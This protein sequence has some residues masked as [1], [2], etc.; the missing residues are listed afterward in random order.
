MTDKLLGL[1]AE[2]GRARR[3][4]EFLRG[5]ERKLC[6][7]VRRALPFVARK[8]MP[9]KL[10]EVSASPITELR[11]KSAQ[12]AA[13]LELV[14]EPGGSRA[15][16][17]FDGPASAM[18][19]ACTLGGSVDA[20]PTL[21]ENGLTAAQ[22]ALVFRIAESVANGLS[23][24]LYEIAGV[25]LSPIGSRRDD[26]AMGEPAPVACTLSIDFGSGVA[27]LTLAVALD[28][29]AQRASVA[30]RV[31]EQI[32]ARVAESM[33][34]V[35]LELIAELARIRMPLGKLASLSIGDVLPLSV[36]VDDAVAIRADGR[37]LLH[38]RPT[39]VGGQIALRI[40]DGHAA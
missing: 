30:E 21:D 1:A 35:E 8:N 22:Q 6:G 13:V 31:V 26:D 2:G 23:D 19:L 38:G 17:M 39:G 37:V 5:H 15:M 10:T 12:P 34:E 28:A 33:Q 24:V 25:R 14:T 40:V 36:K 18:V 7:A 20:L 32:D 29:I 9:V 11:A 16:L 27:Q 3:G 4:I